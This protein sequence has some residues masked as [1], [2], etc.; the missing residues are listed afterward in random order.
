MDFVVKV[1]G[2]DPQHVLEK[3]LV[4]KISKFF[5]DF[6]LRNFSEFSEFSKIS[7]SRKIFGCFKRNRWF[8]LNGIYF[9]STL[10]AALP[11]PAGLDLVLWSYYGVLWLYYEYYGCDTLHYGSIMEY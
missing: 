8:V 9:N 2:P 3:I 7:S 6:F 4:Q 1:G 5:D 10:P 11:G